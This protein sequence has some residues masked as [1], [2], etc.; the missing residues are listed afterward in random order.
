MERSLV[1]GCAVLLVSS[2]A[3]LARAEEP[4]PAANPPPAAAPADLVRLKSGGLLRGTI[5][6]LVPGDTVT[7]V[8]VSGQTRTFPMAEVEYAGPANEAPTKAAPSSTPPASTEA[9]PTDGKVKPYVTVNA[10]NARLHLE[11]TP[12]GLTFHR[13]SGSAISESYSRYG[14]VVTTAQGYDRLCTTPCD[15]TI[16]AGTESLALSVPG[17]EPVDAEPVTFPAGQSRVVGALESRQ[18]TRVAGYL[19]GTVGI[20]GGLALTLVGALKGTGD[21]G[22]GSG[23]GA[24]T[25][26]IIA[27]CGLMLGGGIVGGILVRQRDRAT[28][29]VG[30]NQLEPL[31]SVTGLAFSGTL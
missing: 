20:V 19:V 24:S 16:P 25:P 13:Q 23:T 27:G 10:A 15:I 2:F 1:A 26:L 9:E 12:P 4:A 8:T 6:E 30:S 3:S 21:A 31:P 17:K 22:R 18:G 29:T 11:S 14:G 28:V 5:S 7:I